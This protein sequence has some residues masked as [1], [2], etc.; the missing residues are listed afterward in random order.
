[1]YKVLGRLSIGRHSREKRLSLKHRATPA[2]KSSAFGHC[3]GPRSP[4]PQGRLVTPT[5][6]PLWGWGG[7]PGP[8]PRGEGGVPPLLPL[9]RGKNPFFFTHSSI[10]PKEFFGGADTV[11]PPPPYNIYSSCFFFTQPVCVCVCGAESAQ[12]VR[13]TRATY[14]SL[15]IT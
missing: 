1:M 10:A 5:R 14:K 12:C 13:A 9:S 15:T 4:A 8:P 2:R 11:N 7:T 3:P 6:R